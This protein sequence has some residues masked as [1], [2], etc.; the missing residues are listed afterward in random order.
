VVCIAG[1]LI[2]A[3]AASRLV[4]GFHT[5]G[6]IVLGLGGRRAGVDQFCS[7][8]SETATSPC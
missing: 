2:S 8:L 6:E 3:I 7:C 5:S 4:L 1:L